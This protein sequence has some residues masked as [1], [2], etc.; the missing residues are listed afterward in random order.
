[1]S[2]LEGNFRDPT[3][4]LAKRVGF[5]K[6][7]FHPMER[8]MRKILIIAVSVFFLFACSYEVPQKVSLITDANYAFTIGEFSKSLS[9]YMSVEKIKEYVNNSDDSKIKYSVYDYNPP[10]NSSL[11]KPIQEYLVDMTIAEIPVDVGSYL[12]KMDFSGL[13]SDG[14]TLGQK[15]EIPNLS[16]RTETSTIEFPDIAQKFEDETINIINDLPLPE[17]SITSDAPRTVTT[18]ITNPDFKTAEFY[19]GGIVLNV[20]RTSGTPSAGFKTDFTF[21][22]LSESGTVLS[23]VENVNISSGN[24]NIFFSLDK[25][26][27]T[28]TLNLKIYGEVSG[29]SVAN[30]CRYSL[31]AKF[32]PGTK[33]SKITG[34][35]D[36]IGD[37]GDIEQYVKLSTDETFVKCQIA[38]GSLEFVS[39]KPA[40]WTG[41]TAK[42]S[43]SGSIS[44]ALTL[45]EGRGF[46]SVEDSSAFMHKKL[47]LAGSVY[48][49]ETDPDGK[50]I[51]KDK[52]SFS[53]NNA[54][55][56]FPNGEQPD[57]MLKTVCKISK[58]GYVVLDLSSKE[59]LL[60]FKKETSFPDDLTNFVE[61]MVLVNSGLEISYN[62]TLSKGA[63]GENTL[64]LEIASE[65]LKINDTDENKKSMLPQKSE[66]LTSLSPQDEEITVIPK[67][68]SIDFDIKLVL[69]RDEGM[70]ENY[71][72]L[73]NVEL[74]GA[75]EISVTAK[76]VFD[77]KS[78]KIKSQSTDD[79]TKSG[80]ED[81]Q[82]SFDK[83]FSF[84]KDELGEESEFID[85]IK[86]EKFPL[87]IYF[88]K[89]ELPV[90][91]SIDFSG[92][93]SLKTS[94][95]HSVPVLSGQKIESKSVEFLKMDEDGVVVSEFSNKNA[96]GHAD[97]AE[98]FNNSRSENIVLCYDILL[99]GLDDTIEI[100][101][102]SYEALKTADDEEIPVSVKLSARLVVPLA[103]KLDAPD[104][105]KNITEIN[106]LKLAKVNT[107]EDLFGRGEATSL[108][109]I[110]KY[111]D[112][113]QSVNLI[114]EVDNGLFSYSEYGR[115][116]SIL[117]ETNLD[118]VEI[119]DYDISL[120]KG[121]E[122]IYTEDVKAMLKAY[123]F[124]PKIVVRL[125][126]GTLQISRNAEFKI[127]LAVKIH[128][129]GKVTI[130]GD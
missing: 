113:I 118:D 12:E 21:E 76:P 2:G 63:D 3:F 102:E 38:A 62:N 69:P 124:M 71:A 46:S 99:G 29:G 96:S 79:L 80:E 34:F 104:T 59:D 126:D 53:C 44:G 67:D 114:Y 11:K 87:Y 48:S 47:D 83:L 27:I 54:T 68:S 78:V 61:E 123:P 14:I 42:L 15:I 24:E 10:S 39:T 92:T 32:S 60:H 103:L 129:S 97:I 111:I 6:K 100:T 33:F 108:D 43:D 88:Q 77:W 128:S 45:P 31:N 89:P 36:E 95:S 98:L 1:M 106:V 119:P 122:K 8:F 18:S 75:Y 9:E 37:S 107:D 22:L 86:F 49:K 73:K 93:L 57:V 82:L 56:V 127:N 130:F 125:P 85:N 5:P 72:V 94:D 7:F 116:G 112:L 58:A 117:F 30:L 17:V 115:S 41:V 84:L 74:N 105:D 110:E 13:D 25:K 51:F 90:L 40:G 120:T 20:L 16:E 81:T 4:S 64:G 65:L 52:I 101:K 23:K 121:N 109:D 70:P 35:T 50:I 26:T 91:D 55:L 66:T 28:N 19:S